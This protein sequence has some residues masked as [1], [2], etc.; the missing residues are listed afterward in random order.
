MNSGGRR[1]AWLLLLALVVLMTIFCVSIAS[2]SAMVDKECSDDAAECA[3]PEAAPTVA[4]ETSMAIIEY[5]LVEEGKLDNDEQGPNFQR[6]AVQEKATKRA[7]SVQEWTM[8]VT[9]ENENEN[10]N[11]NIINVMSDF[12]MTLKSAPYAA[13]FFETKGVLDAS[14]AANK[15]FEFV[16]VEAPELHR[17]ATQ[18][19]RRAAAKAE[20]AATSTTSTTSTTTALTTLAAQVPFSE[21]FSSKSCKT[22]S[23]STS[24]SWSDDDMMMGCIF[25]NLSGDATLI[26][27][28]PMFT[29]LKNP[30]AG[31]TTAAIAA[32]TTLTSPSNDSYEG[33]FATYSHLAAF[34]RGASPAQVQA[35]LRMAVTAYAQRLSDNNNKK[36]SPSSSPV[37]FSTS[38][39][40]V[41]W[42]HFRLDSRPKYYTYRP[43]AKL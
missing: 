11:N 4:A 29:A 13:Y 3:N 30:D 39:L 18:T 10:K 17:F 8:L 27:P 33:Q 43:F 15:A 42:L 34:C 24:S 41:A 7:I 1:K 21:R 40:G 28:K 2:S 14:A 31:E 23:S 5:V 26:A 37:W 35:V 9:H 6:F 32:A 12:I 38:G 25:D 20:A 22:T 19:A 36:N 16:L